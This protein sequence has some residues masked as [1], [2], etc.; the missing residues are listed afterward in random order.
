[1]LERLQL[2][3][4]MKMINHE[5]YSSVLSILKEMESLNKSPCLHHGDM[6]LKNLLVDDN[7]KIVSVFDWE[8][9]V[10]SIAPYWDLSISLHDLTVDEQ[11]H[12][13]KGYGITYK[14]FKEVAPFVKVFN[15]L[16]YAP[17][18]KKLSDSRQTGKLDQYRIRLSGLSDL[19]SI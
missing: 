5:R 10:S 15:L 18:I 12:F 3:Q 19:F 6:R 7:H 9:C 1:M 2:L 17:V 8:N 14:I 16:N 13:L 11:L 4:Q